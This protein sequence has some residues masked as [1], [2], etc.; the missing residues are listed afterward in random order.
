MNLVTHGDENDEQYFVMSQ[1]SGVKFISFLPHSVECS[2]NAKTSR[3]NGHFRE[4]G[5]PTRRC[6][7]V[8]FWGGG[9]ICIE[10]HE[11]SVENIT[12]GFFCAAP[13][14][15]RHSVGGLLG[16]ARVRAPRPVG[17]DGEAVSNTTQRTRLWLSLLQSEERTA[18]DLIGAKV[19]VGEAPNPVAVPLVGWPGRLTVLFLDLTAKW[20]RRARW[21]WSRHVPL[22]NRLAFRLILPSGDSEL[23][24]QIFLR[25]CPTRSPSWPRTDRGDKKNDAAHVFRADHGFVSRH[26]ILR[27]A[28]FD[29]HWPS[30]R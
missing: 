2:E 13:T 25:S 15:Y 8:F 11:T 17:K 28:I 26:S 27:S 5:G 4:S 3:W 7:V 20:F 16:S 23:D 6:C 19:K 21:K 14:R 24:R 9:G 10:L 30:Y 1:S 12:I 29:D 22:K 18:R